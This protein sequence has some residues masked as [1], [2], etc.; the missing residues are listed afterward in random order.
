MLRWRGMSGMIASSRTSCAY[1]GEDSPNTLKR[2]ERQCPSETGLLSHKLSK[3]NKTPSKKQE[4]YYD[5]LECTDKV[6]G[7]P[8]YASRSMARAHRLVRLSELP[9]D[10]IVRR[11]R[12]K[13][14]V[15]PLGE[16][17]PGAGDRCGTGGAETYS[18]MLLALPSRFSTRGSP[19]T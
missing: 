11:L 19:Q 9:P 4:K 14:V 2:I 15:V 18:S 5:T 10:L 6:L 1:T 13:A 8:E 7:H 12:R 16:G 17:D 3:S